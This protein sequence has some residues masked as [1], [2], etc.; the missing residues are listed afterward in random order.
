MPV[1]VFVKTKLKEHLTPQSIIL[2]QALSCHQFLAC[3]LLHQNV[4][5]VLSCNWDVYK[6]A[7][8]PSTD[9]SGHATWTCGLHSNETHKNIVAADWIKPQLLQSTMARSTCAFSP[10]PFCCCI[11]SAVKE[12]G[13]C[14]LFG[15]NFFY[16]ALF[17]INRYIHWEEIL[18]TIRLCFHK[19]FCHIHL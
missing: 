2:L 5:T 19:C 12:L 17:W 7:P 18:R 11:F 10:H 3:L 4:T 1:W 8:E 15:A 16:F 9:P 14:K 13:F 6:S